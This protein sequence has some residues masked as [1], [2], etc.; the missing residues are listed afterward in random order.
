M[1]TIAD[2]IVAG[3]FMVIFLLASRA[4][5]KV[6]RQRRVRREIEACDEWGLR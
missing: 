6:I 2:V 4:A 5:R 3:T 1:V